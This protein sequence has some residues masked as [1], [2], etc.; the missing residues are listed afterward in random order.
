MNYYSGIANGYDKLH[1]EEQLE[2][3]E[4]IK[5]HLKVKGLLLDIGAGTGISTKFF[6][7]EAIAL[8]PSKGMLEKYDGKKVCA[9]AED[10][11]FEDKTFSTI[12]SITALHHTDID[13]A[14]K[15][16]KR[17]AKEDCLFAFTILKKAKNFEEIKE[18]LK[19]NF[20]LKEYDSKKDLILIS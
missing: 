17:V 8:D 5:K 7:V 19:N 9:K 18:K 13:K 3:L 12:I 15:E 20:K 1:K 2:K 6:E 14:I 10:L 11:P 4:I 16:I